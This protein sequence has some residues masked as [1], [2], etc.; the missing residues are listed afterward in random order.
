MRWA[1]VHTIVAPGVAFDVF[2]QRSVH[3]TELPHMISHVQVT[4]SGRSAG[5]QGALLMAASCGKVG[6]DW[7][8]VVMIFS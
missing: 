2:C 1:V 6:G 4:S 7:L 3:P 5:I 8:T